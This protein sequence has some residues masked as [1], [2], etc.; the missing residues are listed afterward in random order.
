VFLGSRHFNRV[1]I[2]IAYYFKFPYAF[3]H[4]SIF[5]D[6]TD[7][8]IPG[9][10][11]GSY[12]T[13]LPFKE[14][15]RDRIKYR[16]Y[17]LNKNNVILYYNHIFSD[18]I[19]SMHN[20]NAHTLL[21]FKADI[22]N[23]I[24]RVADFSKLKY[25]TNRNKSLL[26]RL[27]NKFYILSN[28]LYKREVVKSGYSLDHKHTFDYVAIIDV[29]KRKVLYLEK[30]KNNYYLDLLYPIANQIVPVIQINSSGIHLNLFDL[31][32]QEIHTVSWSIDKIWN[33]VVDIVNKDKN[34]KYYRD[35]LSKDVVG[36]IYN[37]TLGSG[38]YICTSS[39]ERDNYV[40]GFIRH[41]DVHI[42]V[43]RREYKFNGLRLK[44]MLTRD[45]LRCEL[46]LDIAYLKV[47]NS[48][49]AFYK[50]HYKQT[51]ILLGEFPISSEITEIDLYNVL[52]SDKCY[53][54]LYQH[55]KGISITKKDLCITPYN[56]EAFSKFTMLSF[57]KY[58]FIIRVPTDKYPV[59]FAV[60]DIEKNRIY[61]F[62]S[63][64]DFKKAL[65]APYYYD[66]GYVL[67]HLKTGNKLIFF[68]SSSTY[69]LAIDLVK[70][71]N[72]LQSVRHDKCIEK[73][74]EYVED[75]VDIFDLKQLLNDVIRRTHDVSTSNTAIDIVNYH[76]GKKS[77][78]LYVV[79][80]YNVANTKYI[81]L[82]DFISTENGILLKLIN[83]YMYDFVLFCKN[84][85]KGYFSSYSWLIQK[86]CHRKDGELSN[87]SLEIVCNT[88]SMFTDVISNRISTRFVKEHYV[89]ERCVNLGNYMIV[90]A[91][92]QESLARK[93]E[94]F[95]LC[96]LSLGGLL[97]RK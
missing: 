85:N 8:E 56:E 88:K 28:E 43:Q 52:Y 53:H 1:N 23:N 4:S 80:E 30:R 29:S 49:I 95:I 25:A 59:C 65:G 87:D 40:E 19:I 41:F 26:F 50:D 81:G 33:V 45:N 83:Y 39:A 86:I 96:E 6:V 15:E 17:F 58:L 70:L 10:S 57:K 89:T 24:Y 44:V 90:K 34:L 93:K 79:A 60:I 68:K 55:E 82:F 3:K 75:F 76:V 51:K 20:S 97:N 38:W 42:Q 16:I 32:S 69:L 54:V 67:H 46:E 2:K 37:V 78:K 12:T 91:K 74:F 14:I 35:K 61:P 27:R 72:K 63:Q 73:Y 84:K 94:V 62:T 18:E 71:T 92:S 7:I 13:I 64:Y 48:P 22:A 5:K 47:G 36:Q 77:E 9:D 66:L 21:W 31:L 11:I